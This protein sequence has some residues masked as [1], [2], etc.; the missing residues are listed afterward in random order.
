MINDGTTVYESPTGIPF[1]N[2][3]AGV[4]KVFFSAKDDKDHTG[5]VNFSLDHVRIEAPRPR[6]GPGLPGAGRSEY[7]RLGPAHEYLY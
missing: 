6:P 4:N 2:A 1:R 3:S 5:S 7:Q